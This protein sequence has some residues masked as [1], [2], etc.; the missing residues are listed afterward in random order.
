MKNNNKSNKSLEKINKEKGT[1]LQKIFCIYSGD[2]VDWLEAPIR[3]KI[4]KEMIFHFLPM[5]PTTIELKN[6]II[7]IEMSLTFWI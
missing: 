5:P 7:C 6:Q 2:E 3:C 1:F 4:K